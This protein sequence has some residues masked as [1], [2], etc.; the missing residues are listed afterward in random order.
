MT[1]SDY[2]KEGEKK[3]T[4]MNSEDVAAMMA[5]SSLALFDTNLVHGD[6]KPGNILIDA[7]GKNSTLTDWGNVKQDGD[8]IGLNADGTFR[9]MAPEQIGGIPATQKS[10]IFSL[11]YTS[12]E[13]ITAR[14]ARIFYDGDDRCEYDKLAV[15]KYQKRN[16]S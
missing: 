2:L 11:C 16:R 12:Y 8:P 15:V 4:R 3:Q 10:D 5:R 6:I 9:Y 7:D 13:S 1:L 14:P